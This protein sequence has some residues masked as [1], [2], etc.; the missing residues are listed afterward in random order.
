MDPVSLA[1]ASS[2]ATLVSGFLSAA[3]DI[4]GGKAQ[5]A[6]YN[7]QSG[8]ALQRAQIQEQNAKYAIAAGETNALEAG[9][10]GKEIVG[11]IKAGQGASN[12]NVNAGSS[13]DVRASQTW[14]TQFD[15]SAIR[16]NA[17]RRA[18]GHEVEAAMDVSQASSYSA[19][20]K[21]STTASYL[22]AAADLVGAG[23][24][25]ASQW[26][27]ASQSFGGGGGSS[28]PQPFAYD[29]SVYGV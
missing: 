22:G 7:Y 3:G 13:R 12:V 20:A 28:S 19:A 9:T 25:V 16:T 29:N 24:K 17:A 1:G 4:F 18:Y 27:Q 2:G 23:G 14:A 8:L 26:Y 10:R 15:E 21:T 11:Q 6:M 5:S